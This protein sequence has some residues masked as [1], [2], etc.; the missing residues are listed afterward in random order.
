V[1][2][3][4]S[5]L[6]C[7]SVT[8]AGC[9]TRAPTPYRLSSAGIGVAVRSPP[10]SDIGVVESNLVDASGSAAEATGKTFGGP[11]GPL[12]LIVA[13]F[14]LGGDVAECDHKLLAAYPGLPERS[15]AIVQREFF[16]SD[17]QDQFIAVLQES[18]S[19]P[20][21]HAEIVSGPDSAA[22]VDQLVAAARQHSLAHLFVVEIA[23]VSVRPFGKGCDSWKVWPR[24]SV[25]LWRVND[26]NLVLDFSFGYPQPFVAAPLSEMKAVFDEPGALRARLR[27]TYEEAARTFS[28]RAMF[29]FPP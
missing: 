15:P 23:N 21:A 7:L 28:N 12:G 3:L 11:L 26:R 27:S 5:L 14:A 13:P 8:F 4:V 17:L 22:G 10:A 2:V 20:I 6:L 24:M 25:E 18:T 19:I 1:R 29:Q 9:A 16:P